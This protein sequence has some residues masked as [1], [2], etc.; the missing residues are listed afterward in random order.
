MCHIHVSLPAAGPARSGWTSL[1]N[2]SFDRF[3]EQR[4]TSV[5]RHA[6]T[7]SSSQLEEARCVPCV[8]TDH[9]KGYFR[10]STC[11]C[12]CVTQPQPVPL[13][14]RTFPR[15]FPVSSQKSFNISGRAEGL[16]DS[17]AKEPPDSTL[18]PLE[19]QPCPRCLHLS[20]VVPET[21][22]VIDS[23]GQ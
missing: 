19:T 12:C 23:R 6:Y 22:A 4:E 20:R 2:Q 9:P 16:L 17:T 18:H 15:W 5:R 8:N 10:T 1:W 7:L 21:R 3:E 11:W 13:A 14:G